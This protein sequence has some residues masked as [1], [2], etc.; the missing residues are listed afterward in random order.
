ME[1]DENNIDSGRNLIHTNHN[2]INKRTKT[3]LLINNLKE[4]SKTDSN[5]S[6]SNSQTIEEE[7]LTE[8]V[9]S[10]NP[11]CDN[12]DMKTKLHLRDIEEEPSKSSNNK[13]EPSLI[14]VNESNDNNNNNAIF[15]FLEIIE[16]K[17]NDESKDDDEEEDD[18]NENDSENVRNNNN[19]SKLSISIYD[20]KYYKERNKT[21]ED[22][23]SKKTWEKICDFF[24]KILHSKPFTIVFALAIISNL[25]LEHIAY[26]ALA[27]ES[28]YIIDVIL[29]SCFVFFCF[30]FSMSI[31]FIKEYKFS[32]FF[33]ADLFAIIGLIP[34]VNLFYH[35]SSHGESD[36][37]S[38]N[39][40][41]LQNNN[42]LGIFI[43]NT[44]ITKTLR[45]TISGGK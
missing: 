43:G 30:E 27:K 23:K 6:D 38:S 44:H 34:S 10:L 32:F 31:I 39:K 36:S 14:K 2:I 24:E 40:E 3:E 7:E 20:N 25:F 21:T 9:N 1:D 37:I 13:S 42:I 15:N 33:Y 19:D 29:L 26:L 35:D 4:T 8:T 12:K 28:E 22:K 16:K 5:L 41:V 11:L 17:Q 45:V 18:D